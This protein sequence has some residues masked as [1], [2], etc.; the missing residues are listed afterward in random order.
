[1]F[2]Q[3]IRFVVVLAAVAPLAL[4]GCDKAAPST[5]TAMFDGL[6]ESMVEDK[7]V[8]LWDTVPATWQQDVDG[9]VHE[10]GK[11]V[12]AKLYDD[13]MAT[14]KRVVM[15][16]KDKKQFIMNTPMVKEQVATMTATEKEQAAETYGDIVKIGEAITSSDLSTV[17]GL[18]K[19]NMTN[20]L[21]NYGPELHVA[22]MSIM[23][24][25]AAE[26]EDAAQALEFFTAVK[27]LS[28]KVDSET[29]DTAMVSITMPE[30]PAGVNLIPAQ[31]PMS[32]VDGRWVPTMMAAV[33]PQS[34]AE[35]KQQLDNEDMSTSS[36][37]VAQ[38]EAVL[39]MVNLGLSHFENATTQEE[40]DQAIAGLA[41]MMGGSDQHP[42]GN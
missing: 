16:L 19:F 15:V 4:I 3:L 9:L 26:E 12:P 27:K 42:G 30:L 28:A 8:L 41:G 39:K 38:A 10:F 32:K 29:G 14:M 31:V 20:F 22:M 37:Q 18:K 1:M 17:A 7:P 11:K 36:Q 24:T 21:T 23:K 2:S 6:R 33:V 25:A 35:A 13:V 5:P 34:L 40:F